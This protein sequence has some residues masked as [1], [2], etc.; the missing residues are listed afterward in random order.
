M[1]INNLMQS[2][3]FVFLSGQ[4]LFCL[5]FF[6]VEGRQ[7]LLEFRFGC[8]IFVFHGEDVLVD[9][10]FVFQEIVKLIYTLPLKDFL[11]LQQFKLVLQVFYLLL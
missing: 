1:S 3:D 2:F 5:V 7:L 6:E 8:V 9:R 4:Y 10:N 11:V